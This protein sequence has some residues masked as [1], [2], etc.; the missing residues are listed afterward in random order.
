MPNRPSIADVGAAATS[1]ARR[2]IFI[3]APDAA[4]EAF[5]AV[6]ASADDLAYVIHTSGSTGRPL[7]VEIERGAR[8]FPLRRCSG[9]AA[10]PVMPCSLSRRILSI[11]LRASCCR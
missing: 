5:P 3:D 7:G 2:A 1:A 6:D 11:P 8:H 10:A 9:A 4:L